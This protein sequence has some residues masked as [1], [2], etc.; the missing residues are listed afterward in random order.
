MKHL[1]T[2]EQVYSLYKHSFIVQEKAVA[3]DDSAL[4]MLTNALLSPL[5]LLKG[6]IKKGV[7]SAQI[8]ALVQKWGIEYV[9]AIRQFDVPE[10]SESEDDKSSIEDAENIDT[11]IDDNLIEF[12]KTIDIQ[13]AQYDL[14]YI[15]KLIDLLYQ[16]L[17]SIHNKSSDFDYI[18]QRISIYQINDYN[19]LNEIES[20]TDLIDVKKT[21]KIQQLIDSSLNTTITEF[22]NDFSSSDDCIKTIEN[23][24][25]YCEEIKT[26][27][28]QLIDKHK[29]IN[30]SINEAREYKIPK[31]IQRLFSNKNLEQIKQVQGAKEKIT[32]LVNTK[33]LDTIKY[34]AEYIIAKAKESDRKNDKDTAL[35]LQRKWD[36][37]VKNIND[38]FQD[39]IDSNIVMKKVT[40]QVDDDV[41]KNV[42]NDQ[43]KITLLQQLG[44]TEILTEEK[45]FTDRLYAIDAT[46]QGNNNKQHSG[47]FLI[48]PTDKFEQKIGNRTFYFF[49][50]F[51][52]VDYD[53]KKKT[54]IRINP[55]EYIS[56]NSMV[57]NF[58]KQDNR[59]FI[60]FEKNIKPSL[61][62]VN[63]FIY[64]NGG[65]IFLNYQIGDINNV[66][67]YITKGKNEK[68]TLD[69]FRIKGGNVI[70]IKIIQR[71]VIDSDFDK[72]PGINQ[73]RMRDDSG[74]DKAKS[75]HEILIKNL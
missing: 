32:P 40:G 64:S 18:T 4:G 65:D 57:K 70:N 37:G 28:E 39:V 7:R 24:I 69:D 35:D 25:E 49:K 60:V 17:D 50:L 66:S 27:Y 6:S 21:E 44:I 73:Q 12:I 36:I 3:W 22:I 42:E 19:I 47:I 63:A 46:L 29:S 68:Q 15:E 33:R 45:F 54:I 52:Q 72:F 34:E 1:L 41:K 51:A 48:N 53:K 43:K 74:L 9:K 2:K 61:N 11:D 56:S 62:Y 55:F 5:S 13:G 58:Q 16:L 8:A 59:Y 75:N 30:E 31:S 20:N 38:Y 71:F 67:N 14:N 23:V 26:V 10:E